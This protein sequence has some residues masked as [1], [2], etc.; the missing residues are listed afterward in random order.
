MRDAMGG[1]VALVIIV[2]FIVIAL[3][4]MAFNVNYT[5]AF[6]MKNKIISVYE[7]FNGDCEKNSKSACN[8]Q[9][10]KYAESLGYSTGDALTCPSGYTMSSTKLYCS[11]RIEVTPNVDDDIIVDDSTKYY[12][13]ILTKINIEVPIINNALD[14]KAFQITGDTKSFK[15]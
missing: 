15:E 11:Q 9:I 13:K 14:L 8:T 7:D 6:R 4:Y 5:K 2:V 10:T 1:T 3:G 12:Y